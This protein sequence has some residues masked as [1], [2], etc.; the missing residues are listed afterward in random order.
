[1]PGDTAQSAVPAI[2]RAAVGGTVISPITLRAVDGPEA[3]AGEVGGK[4]SGLDRGAAGGGSEG[5]A[6]LGQ[7]GQ[8]TENSRDQPAPDM[9][10]SRRISQFGYCQPGASHVI[11]IAGAADSG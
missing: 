1:M 10:V 3:E 11:T 6:R 8:N 7:Q 5:E 2:Q 4:A 9:A